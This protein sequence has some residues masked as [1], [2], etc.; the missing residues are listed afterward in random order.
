MKKPIMIIGSIVCLA[1]IIE[2]LAVFF[3]NHEDRIE[4]VVNKTITALDNDGEGLD[5]LFLE[6][7]KK[8]S[9]TFKKNLA[10]LN[11]F[12][13]GKS[14]SVQDL[15]IYHET[16][17]LFRAYAVVTT[18]KDKYFVCIQ[19]SGSR[20]VDTE[21][22]NQLIIDKYDNFKGK[23]IIEKKLMKD[24]AKQARTYGIT[25]RVKGDHDK[26]LK[27]NEKVEKL[28]KEGK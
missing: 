23:K 14:T 10:E 26:Y 4:N 12:Y 16:E 22:I 25:I 18:D 28:I 5:G 13:Q 7:P 8:Y 17:N 24:Y 3:G 1:A 2:T 15:Y 20:M 9:L 6:K 11:E 19:A 27:E 21:G